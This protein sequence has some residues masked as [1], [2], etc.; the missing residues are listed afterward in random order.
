M[1][2]K[3][4]HIERI[5][6]SEV[7]GIL[8]GDCYVFPK[9][10]G[11]NASIWMDDAELCC[12]SRNRQLSL[13]NDNGGFMR[14]ILD[15]KDKYELLIKTIEEN[16]GKCTIYGEFLIPHTL[17]TYGDSAWRKFYVFDV[18][19][20]SDNGMRYLQYEDYK[21]ICEDYGVEFIPP[22]C[23]IKNPLEES[24]YKQ[25]ESNKYL[26]QDGKGFGEGVVVKNYDFV[27]KHGRRTWAKVVTN[28]FKTK[29]TRD[30]TP[31]KTA[32][33]VVEQKIANKFITAELVSK[34]YSKIVT[35]CEGWSSKYIPRLL[36]TVFYCLVKEECWEFVKHFKN[37]TV[38]FKR[39]KRF[40]DMQVRAFKSELF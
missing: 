20:F 23:I 8:D 34:E 19:V 3:Y 40:S 17:R 13:E 5:G 4:Q 39:L 18:A 12:G 38:D 28:E 29:H 2:I 11:T 30:I 14:N 36:N 7:E 10:D 22:L 24:I 25:L 37:P 26:I 32:Q 33:S 9:L 27:N 15:Q 35:E 16:Y 31:E 6:T 1:F 21:T